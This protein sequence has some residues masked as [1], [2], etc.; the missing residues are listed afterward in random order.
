MT[1]T[2]PITIYHNDNNNNNTTTNRTSPNQAKW[3][4]NQAKLDPEDLFAYYSSQRKT[5]TRVSVGSN[6]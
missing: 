6:P 3:V 2:I 4:K 5:T 1:S